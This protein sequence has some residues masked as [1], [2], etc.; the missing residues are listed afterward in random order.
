MHRFGAGVVLVGGRFGTGV[1]LVRGSDPL[2]RTRGGLVRD[3]GTGVRPGRMAGARYNSVP[4]SRESD[5]PRRTENFAVSKTRGGVA[6]TARKP[7][8]TP[9]SKTRTKPR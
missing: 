1:V 6:E 7:G 8:L 4:K 9:V 5:V 2:P 3:F